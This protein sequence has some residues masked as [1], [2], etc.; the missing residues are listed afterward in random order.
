[1]AF[2]IKS[3]CVMSFLLFSVIHLWKYNMFD[4]ICEI[5]NLYEE[6]VYFELPESER[7]RFFAIHFCVCPSVS[8]P[9]HD[10]TRTYNYAMISIREK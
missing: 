6:I 7:K 3:K 8:V 2:E 1:M 10:P 5:F 9:V 4:H